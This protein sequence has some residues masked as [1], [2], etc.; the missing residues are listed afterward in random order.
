MAEETEIFWESGLADEPAGGVR[1]STAAGFWIR[2]AAQLLDNVFMLLVWAVV[3]FIA[4]LLWGTRVE[5]STLLRASLTAFNLLFGAFYYIL[6][7]WIF[8][9]TVGKALLRLRV[10]TLSG[11]SLSLAT[12]V[13]RWI[14]YL[15]SLLPFLAGYV[16]VGVRRDK[17]ALHDLIARTR[18]VRV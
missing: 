3:V 15:L 11:G 13:L 10:V 16:M 1:E 17:R 5:T 2:F 6:L 14:G 12:S 18:V 7:H 4:S 8:G 9:Q